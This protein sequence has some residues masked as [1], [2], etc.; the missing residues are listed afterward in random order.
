MNDRLGVVGAVL[1]GLGTVL[2]LIPQRPRRLAPW[3]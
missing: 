2:Q 1:L 3:R